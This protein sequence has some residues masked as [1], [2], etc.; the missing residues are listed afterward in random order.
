MTYY[1]ITNISTQR[2][3]LNKAALNPSFLKFVQKAELPPVGSRCK[4][5]AQPAQGRPEG[6]SWNSPLPTIPGLP[7]CG[8]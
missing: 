2:K 4:G 6:S 3:E 1:L 7:P 5:L 8:C